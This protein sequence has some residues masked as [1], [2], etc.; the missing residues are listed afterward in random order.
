M[1]TYICGVAERTMAAKSPN[2]VTIG[3][4]SSTT[5][6]AKTY[7]GTAIL[8]NRV[9]IGG[10]IAAAYIQNLSTTNLYVSIGQNGCDSTNNYH[11]ILQPLQQ[12]DC[13]LHRLQVWGYSVAG[14]TVATLQFNRNDDKPV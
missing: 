9:N 2:I 6:D 14:A 11:M 13:S 10:E 1:P 7:K 8:D 4:D 12:L 5:I 3:A